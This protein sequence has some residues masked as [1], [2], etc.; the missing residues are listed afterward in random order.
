MYYIKIIHR[1]YW[2]VEFWYEYKF[3]TSEEAAKKYVNNIWKG[4]FYN[5]DTC[6]IVSS[7]KADWDGSG[8]LVPVENDD[9]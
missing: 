7:G 6:Y 9:C 3:F 5:P 4:L 8:Q 2:E 1:K